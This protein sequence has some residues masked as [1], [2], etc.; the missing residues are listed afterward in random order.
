MPALTQRRLFT[1]EDYYAMAEA[2]VL[3]AEDRVELIDGEILEM[4]P[5][6]S[7]HAAHVNRLN[8]WLTLALGERAVLSVQNP[9][10]LDDFA[11]PEP[12][13]AVLRPRE[14]FYAEAH[15]GPL[16]VLLLIEVSDSSLVFDRQVK[17]P[18]Y[19][20]HGILEVWVVNLIESRIEVHHTPQGREYKE[21]WVPRR[22]ERLAPRA[23][24]ELEITAE[25]ALGLATESSMPSEGA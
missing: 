7:R 19:A 24:P 22:G 5:I 9:L 8:R 20:A 12:D 18:I 14:D 4:S 23:F 17:L 6:G 16:D 2:G 3:A 15:P 25:D 21:T 10:R 11:E 13:L 1:V